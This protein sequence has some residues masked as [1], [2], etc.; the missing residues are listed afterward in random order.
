MHSLLAQSGLMR[1]AHTTGNAG[2]AQIPETGSNWILMRGFTHAGFG[3]TLDQK[4]IPWKIHANDVVGKEI[5]A[6]ETVEPRWQRQ[7]V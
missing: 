3:S 7:V 2:T 5:V 4:P 6:N 1:G